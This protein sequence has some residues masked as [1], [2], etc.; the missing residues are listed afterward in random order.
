MVEDYELGKQI[1]VLTQA[2]QD[3]TG[4]LSDHMKREEDSDKELRERID[5]QFGLGRTKF[6]E[7]GAAMESMKS[8]VDCLEKKIKPRKRVTPWDRKYLKAWA[9]VLGLAVP[10]LAA[11]GF[12]TEWIGKIMET[13]D[14]L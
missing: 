3:L 1:G 12:N 11:A 8:T 2:V 5:H 4:D 7:I 14:K 13:A 9:W 6:E 10:F